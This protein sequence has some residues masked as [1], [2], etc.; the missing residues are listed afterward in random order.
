MGIKQEIDQ[1]LKDAVRGKDEGRRNALRMLLTALKSKEKELRRE[2]DD[3]E[4][5]QVIQSQIKQRKD[6]ADQYR[7]GGR[8][9][10]A[11]AEDAEVNVLRMFLPE[12]LGAAE[13]ERIVDE[14]V[15]ET[16]AQGPRD[17]GKVMKAVMP[18]VAGRAEGKRVNELVRSKLQG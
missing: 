1:A 2:L 11:A 6:S 10:L 7:K 16:G 17:M 5:Q 12:E 4:I 9:D 14:T 8:E 3:S 15:A 18:K 13:L